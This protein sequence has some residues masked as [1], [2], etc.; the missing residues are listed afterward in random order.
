MNPSTLAAAIDH[1]LLK[2]NMTSEEL[3]RGCEVAKTLNVASVCLLPYYVRRCRELLE[4]TSVRATT[5]VGFP[6][7]GAS[8]RAKLAEASAYID[9]GAE[10]LDAVV[11]VSQV[12]S[13]R[14]QAVTL[15]VSQ[16]TQLTHDRGQ[17][18]KLIFENCYL[19]RDQK[20]KLC[21]IASTAGVDW[22]KTSTGFGTSGATAED[23]RL[24]RESCPPSVAVKASGGITSLVQ[25]R[26][27]MRL[28]ATRIGLSRTE[29]ILREASQMSAPSTP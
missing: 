12:L 22:V 14:W 24:M 19:T 28:G 2:P 16:L 4:G 1:S 7:G 23:V 29:E 27:L 10:E 20:L 6:H 9:D 11:N 25:V 15:E 3:E 13:G 5:V 21:E 17:K 18:L 8:L 26:E